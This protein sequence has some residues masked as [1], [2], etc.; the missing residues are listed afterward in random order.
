VKDALIY[1]NSLLKQL[2]SLIEVAIKIDSRLY[3]RELEKKHEVMTSATSTLA[4]S[5][6]ITLTSTI[7]TLTIL[8]SN[9]IN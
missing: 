2:K 7:L 8:T 6:L 5:I 9:S 4:T 1:A 3:E